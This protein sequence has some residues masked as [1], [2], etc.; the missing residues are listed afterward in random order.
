MSIWTQFHYWQYH[1]TL[2]A[3][4]CIDTICSSNTD[5]VGYFFEPYDIQ[6]YRYT[7]LSDAQILFVFTGGRF[8]GARRTR[9]LATFT[10][11]EDG[12]NIE[13]E[14]QRELLGLPPLFAT[15]ELD[16]FMKQKFKAYGIDERAITDHKE[17]ISAEEFIFSETRRKRNVV[18]GI[19]GLI[20]LGHYPVFMILALWAQSNYK[21]AYIAAAMLYPIA[22]ITLLLIWLSNYSCIRGRYYVINSVVV[23]VIGK[24]RISF[25]QQNA[26]RT[27]LGKKGLAKEYVVLSDRELPLSD[28]RGNMC[29]RLKKIWQSGFVI[30]PRDRLAQGRPVAQGMA[31]GTVCV[32]PNKTG[33]GSRTGDG[34]L[35]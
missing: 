33:D 17:E 11:C 32:I 4:D 19:W 31:Q 28:L 5:F 14:F 23:N 26:V 12:C 24:K 2:S 13:M 18:C 8:V 29:T 6:N 20:G 30:V 7:I 9:Y 22:M 16:A 10:D 3:K 27:M 34:S 15:Q 25:P 1:T 35:S 21:I